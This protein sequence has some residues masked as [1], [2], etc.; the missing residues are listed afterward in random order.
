M[1]A[2]IR[3]KIGLLKRERLEHFSSEKG[4]IFFEKLRE[5]FD[6]HGGKKRLSA[7]GV[8]TPDGAHPC[9]P[10]DR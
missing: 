4:G 10:N 8:F 2:K 6:P 5:K 1:R 9:K 3:K 7:N